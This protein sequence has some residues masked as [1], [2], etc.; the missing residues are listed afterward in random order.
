M[1]PAADTNIALRE[2]PKPIP[3]PPYACRDQVASFH[4]GAHRIDRSVFSLLIISR[5]CHRHVGVY[6]LSPRLLSGVEL[7]QKRLVGPVTC[8]DLIDH[9]PQLC[10]RLRSARTCARVHLQ[11]CLGVSV[12]AQ[13]YKRQGGKDDPIHSGPRCAATGAAGWLPQSTDT[14]SVTLRWASGISVSSAHVLKISPTRA[15]SFLPLGSPE[16]ARQCW[17]ACTT[18]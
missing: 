1:A 12:N 13:A 7:R 11:L 8:F 18:E 15:R 10:L 9:L 16:N 5:E 17:S 2:L 3:K 6:K 4:A 14:A